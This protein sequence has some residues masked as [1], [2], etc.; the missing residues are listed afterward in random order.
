MTATVKRL[1]KSR[2]V[3]ALYPQALGV[4]AGC[5]ALSLWSESQVLNPNKWLIAVAI[6][7]SMIAVPTL[8]ICTA[9]LNRFAQTVEMTALHKLDL[10]DLFVSYFRTAINANFAFQI[11]STTQFFILPILSL[12]RH[13][14]L[15]IWAGVGVTAALSTHRAIAALVRFTQINIHER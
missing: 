11:M 2:A 10:A 12:P 7:S 6:V 1:L 13:F 3:E 15:S 9:I 4:I 5:A 14:G 8:T